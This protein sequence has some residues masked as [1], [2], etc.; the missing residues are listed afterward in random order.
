ML[1]IKHNL[2][3]KVA[4]LTLAIFSITF[5][6]GCNPPSSGGGQPPSDIPISIQ[7]PLWGQGQG[8]P[9]NWQQTNDANHK[10]KVKVQTLDSNQNATLY[11]SYSWTYNYNGLSDTWHNQRIEVPQTG[12]F[13]VQVEVESTECTWQSSSCNLP[14]RASTKDFFVQQTFTS[15]PSSVNVPVSISNLIGQ[16]CSCQ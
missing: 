13:V 10:V 3:L 4:V 6:S 11:K 1:R 12:M 14:Y 2:D 8:T 9:I 15:K 16:D 5:L 7:N